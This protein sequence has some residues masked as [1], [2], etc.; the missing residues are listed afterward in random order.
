MSTESKNTK[1]LK[2]FKIPELSFME[3]VHLALLWAKALKGIIH[4]A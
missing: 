1:R 2:R 3:K 4:G